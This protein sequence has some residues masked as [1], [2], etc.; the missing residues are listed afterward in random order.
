MGRVDG[1]DK[2]VH[3]EHQGPINRATQLHAEAAGIAHRRRAGV[4]QCRCRGDARTTVPF[5]RRR[6][7]SL[8]VGS[9]LRVR[10]LTEFGCGYR[11]DRTYSRKVQR[12]SLDVAL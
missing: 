7:W 1:T 4:G 5:P 12:D 9:I 2:H 10:V 8:S 11:Y 6:W 3:D